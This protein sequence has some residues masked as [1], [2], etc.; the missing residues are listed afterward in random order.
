MGVSPQ[1]IPIITAVTAENPLINRR[2]LLKIT[3]IT[4]LDIP[5]VC[6]VQISYT[7]SSRVRLLYFFLH[8]WSDFDEVFSG[9]RSWAKG[10]RKNTRI[11]KYP[12]GCHGNLKFMLSGHISPGKHGEIFA[13]FLFGVYGHT[14]TKLGGKVEGGWENGL[15][16]FVSMATKP[17]LWYSTKTAVW[18]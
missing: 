10:N 3:L 17:L 15:I 13:A 1:F 4:H 5:R 8:F 16:P 12:R 14:C 18:L 6:P 2:R 9:G 7:Y 11:E